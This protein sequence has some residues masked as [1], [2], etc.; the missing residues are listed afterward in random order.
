MGSGFFRVRRLL[1]S[2]VLILL[3]ASAWAQSP[4]VHPIS[5]R[6]YALPMGVAG[7]D[8]LDRNER[9]REEAPT[10]ALR[11]LG[12]HPESVVADIGA[13]SGYYVVRL[14][15]LVGPKGRV[16]AN[17]LQPGMLDIIRGRLERERIGNVEVVLGTPTNPRLPRASLDLALMVD[18]YH[19]FSEP[20]AM[21][22]QVRDALKPDGRL[23]LLE[24]R[25]EDPQVPIRPEHKMT[26]S[27]AKLEVEA[28]GFALSVVN[29]ELPWQHLLI[30][31][32]KGK[33]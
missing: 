12:I 25:A 20:Q 22:R 29:E 13:G 18:V 6:R 4:G 8:W 9:E 11:I 17:D 1:R 14:A 16:Y 32:R 23:V 30:F 26:V 7:A 27:Q 19:E 21:L 24:Y 33:E 5:G 31:T 28:E 10:R 3:G 15:A 2:I